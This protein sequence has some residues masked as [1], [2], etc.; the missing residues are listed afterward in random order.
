MDKKRWTCPDCAEVVAEDSA[1]CPYCGYTDAAS[2][3]SSRG[4]CPTCGLWRLAGAAEQC[5]VCGGELRDVASQGPTEDVRSPCDSAVGSPPGANAVAFGTANATVGAPEI[6]V[7]HDEV[8]RQKMSVGDLELLRG[9]ASLRDDGVIT[10]A[11][12]EDK[13][14]EILRRM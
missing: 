3:F 13:K 7:D 12:F 14:A 11:E 1:I 2:T 9:L 6:M 10:E 8:A 4:Y 5:P